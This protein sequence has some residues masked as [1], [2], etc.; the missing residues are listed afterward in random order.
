[1]VKPEAIMTAWYEDCR[2][3]Y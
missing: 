2:C 3:Y 1:V